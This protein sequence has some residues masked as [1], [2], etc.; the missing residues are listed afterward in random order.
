[1]VFGNIHRPLQ[2]AA[3]VFR[4]PVQRT[5]QVIDRGW[6]RYGIFED[7]LRLRAFESGAGETVNA[8]A[9]V[10]GVSLEQLAGVFEAAG[11]TLAVAASGSSA[12]GMA[13]ERGPCGR[14]AA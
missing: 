14:A 12:R 6:E 1:M 8:G 10:G 4:P 5:L 9:A 3:P 7:G 11:Q 13:G 2:P